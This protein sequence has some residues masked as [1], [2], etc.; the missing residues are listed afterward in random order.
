MWQN[1]NRIDQITLPKTWNAGAQPGALYVEGVAAS[2]AARDVELKLEYDETPL[3]DNSGL[4]K[5]EDR[6]KL[7][8]LKVDMDIANGQGGSLIDE[9]NEETPGAFTVANLNDTDGD[10]TV[11]KDDSDVS[12]TANGRDEVDLMMLV[13]RKPEPDL[14]DKVKFKVVSGDVKIWE[15]SKKVTE[16]SLTGGTVEFNTTD[17]D[18]TSGLKPVQRAVPCGT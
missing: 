14:G 18:K 12:A 2:A 11:D 15:E 10:G 5:C 1:P 9:D 17:L 6:V 16:V 8:V 13:L 7:T 4:F 3:R